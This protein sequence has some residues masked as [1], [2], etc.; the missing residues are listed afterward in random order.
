M[1]ICLAHFTS[2]HGLGIPSR[3]TCTDWSKNYLS[4]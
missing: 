4:L 1:K 2:T 3:W